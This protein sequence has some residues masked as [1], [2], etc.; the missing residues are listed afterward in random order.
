LYLC[1]SFHN[2]DTNLSEKKYSSIYLCI[3]FTKVALPLLT[4]MDYH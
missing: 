3:H 1:D 4:R 2:F